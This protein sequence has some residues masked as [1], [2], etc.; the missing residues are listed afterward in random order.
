MVYCITN[1]VPYGII[2]HY[3]LSGAI[4]SFY[5]SNV[6]VSV[7]MVMCA[8]TLAYA[9][10][11]SFYQC[12]ISHDVM[13]LCRHTLPNV[14]T[15]CHMELYHYCSVRICHFILLRAVL[16]C[17]YA[18]LQPVM[19]PQVTTCYTT[20][21]LPYLLIC[22]YAT[23]ISHAIVRYHVLLYRCPIPCVIILLLYSDVTICYCTFR[24]MILHVAIW[25]C[26]TWFY[27]H[28]IVCY[29]M[30]VCG[31]MC[32][33]PVTSSYGITCYYINIALS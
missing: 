23:H 32:C 6:L 10:P 21:V 12:M 4:A 33:A 25:Y 30:L 26:A 27:Q 13:P 24:I 18:L 2:C 29:H 20:T 7:I 11:G 19:L 5:G 28:A 8:H 31:N 17:Y 22:F 14:I 9:I 3:L 16:I 1:M 15:P